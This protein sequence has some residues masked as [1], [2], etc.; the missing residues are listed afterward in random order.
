MYHP[1]FLDHFEHPRGQGSLPDATHRGEATDAACGD[2]M[3]LDLCV[4]DGRITAARTRVEGCPG[5]IAVASALAT[6]LPGRPA[7]PNAVTTAQLE[8]LL[9][10]VPRMKRHALTLALSTLRVALQ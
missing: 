5:T 9:G 8:T 1:A 4:I 2:R 6:L 10:E 7:T 3:A